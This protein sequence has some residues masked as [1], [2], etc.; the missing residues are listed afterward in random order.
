MQSSHMNFPTP[1]RFPLSSVP[2]DFGR[3]LRDARISKGWSQAR[4]GSAAGLQRETIVRLEAGARRPCPDSVFRLRTALGLEPTELVPDWPE[5][6]PIG[7]LE[8]GARSRER[9]RALNLSMI[10]VAAAAGVSVST[11]SRFERDI[12]WEA[13]SLLEGPPGS[14]PT[15]AAERLAVALGFADAQAHSRWCYTS[16]D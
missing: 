15:E 11:L 9:R 16:A 14:G 2:D 13:G 8:M 6:S 1:L 3:N 12:R 5:W 4:L 7:M 10:E